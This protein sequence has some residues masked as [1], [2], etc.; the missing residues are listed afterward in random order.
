MQSSPYLWSSR[1]VRLY[2]DT[3][4]LFN[5]QDTKTDRAAA[6][7]GLNWTHACF[8]LDKSNNKIW[9]QNNG[10]II[11]Q[12]RKMFALYY[13]FWVRALPNLHLSQQSL[14]VMLFL[15]FDCFCGF[16]VCRSETLPISQ[17]LS[18]T[19]IQCPFYVLLTTFQ[20]P[21]WIVHL[22]RLIPYT[23]IIDRY[24]RQRW[25][26]TG[27][28]TS[29]ILWHIFQKRQHLCGLLTI[30]VVNNSSIV[31]FCG[32]LAK[33]FYWYFFLLSNLNKLQVL[34]IIFFAG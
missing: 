4:T 18:R 20:A 1:S 12:T 6:H 30:C 27:L 8:G 5:P 28:P 32:M 29:Q 15:L 10:R 2:I 25:K 21:Q 23:L 13:F 31:L 26:I 7:T 19:D 16:I 9:L 11:S 14:T 3:H 22:I 33:A 17:H 34:D 24:L